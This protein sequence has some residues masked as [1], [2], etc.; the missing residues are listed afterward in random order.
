MY[1]SF[2][3]TTFLGIVIVVALVVALSFFASPLIAVLL[4]IPAAVIGLAVMSAQRRRSERQDAESTP[5]LT[6]EGR[7]TSPTG[8]RSR[9][10]PASGEGQ[11]S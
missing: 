11:S 3:F 10:A 4:F 7:P 9:G 2:S 5:P 6:P 8:S 1:G